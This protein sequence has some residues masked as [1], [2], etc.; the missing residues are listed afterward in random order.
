MKRIGVVLLL[1]ALSGLGCLP[2]SFLHDK[3]KPPKVEMAPPPPPPAV[4]PEGI[5]EK[6]A[7]ERVRQLREELE[8]DEKHPDRPEAEKKP[9]A[10]P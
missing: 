8:Y 4:V 9:A 10:K 1:G 3:E 5:T 7:A 6:N 2:T